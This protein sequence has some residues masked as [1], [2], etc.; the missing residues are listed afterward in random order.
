M[1]ELI[2]KQAAKKGAPYF[3]MKPKRKLPH[4]NS[5][6]PPLKSPSTKL[7]KGSLSQSTIKNLITEASED[8]SSTESLI[9]EC[10]SSD[11]G[12]S[13]F[14]LCGPVLKKSTALKPA[15]VSERAGPSYS[16]KEHTKLGKRQKERNRPNR[17]SSGKSECVYELSP[18]QLQQDATFADSSVDSCN[19]A[20]SMTC[21]NKSQLASLDVQKRGI[22]NKRSALSE[23]MD[24]NQHLLEPESCN[25]SGEPSV[26][27]VTELS[28]RNTGGGV[29]EPGSVNR[30]EA[31]EESI[32]DFTLSCDDMI[33]FD[34]FYE[35]NDDAMD[36]SIPWK[37]REIPATAKLT[38]PKKQHD[39]KASLRASSPAAVSTPSGAILNTA[40]AS[41][42]AFR[43]HRNM[44][45]STLNLEVDNLE[46]DAIQ[47]RGVKVH[48]TVPRSSVCTERASPPTIHA[49]EHSYQPTDRVCSSLALS[50][51]GR[52]SSLAAITSFIGQTPSTIAR[53]VS[54]TSSTSRHVDKTSPNGG[55]VLVSSGSKLHPPSI[56]WG[57]SGWSSEGVLQPSRK[58]ISKP[59]L[60]FL[61]PFGDITKQATCI[62]ATKHPHVQR[63]S[64]DNQKAIS[65][66][67][68]SARPPSLPSR[69]QK[70]EKHSRSLP[71]TRMDKKQNSVEKPSTNKGVPSSISPT[72]VDDKVPFA[73]RPTVSSGKQSTAERTIAGEF[74]PPS[75]VPTTSGAKSLQS[76]AKRSPRA[77][78]DFSSDSS[79]DDTAAKQ[80]TASLSHLL[81]DKRLLLGD[82][83][84]K[85]SETMGASLLCVVNLCDRFG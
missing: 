21:C 66:L 68:R 2:A 25:V 44:F 47:K 1:K 41:T 76:G 26:S 18:T 77:T 82:K 17:S 4:K 33:D 46:F 19:V 10:D 48:Q 39:P 13:S 23:I 65:P 36:T 16:T 50:H 38:S 63:A 53:C 37:K 7:S 72:L 9:Q 43:V 57:D 78:V 28:Q 67:E 40:S 29:E 54:K 30:Q 70:V 74:R 6:K 81:K 60:P 51:A 73:G 31:M 20:K 14:E 56:T 59:N 5:S 24:K 69:K 15:S 83:T 58:N 42:S 75:G 32:H 79:E 80:A 62:S 12:S 49:S 8:S 64:D 84:S 3:S 85:K 11:D 52:S 55:D 71:L 61:S 45:Q 35:G 22:L 34:N 27:S